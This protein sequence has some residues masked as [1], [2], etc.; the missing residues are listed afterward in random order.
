MNIIP[1]LEKEIVAEGYI[2][3]PPDA[4][5]VKDN[6]E[7]YVLEIFWK[8]MNMKNAHGPEMFFISKDSSL[9]E[10]EYKISILSDKIKIFAST[11]KG[12]IHAFTT[13]YLIKDGDRRFPICE[14]CDRPRYSHRGLHIDCS[15]H[16]FKTNRIKKIIEELS[17]VKINKLHWHL[18]D[19]QGFRV[20]IDKYP[21]LYTQCQG[22]Y[23][24][25]D[26]ICEVVRF[27]KIHGI[28]VIPE[29]D[30]PG[31]TRAMT[32]AYPN[33]SCSEKEVKLATCGGIYP[34]ILCAGKE[35]VYDF[36]RG[37]LEELIPLFE[38]DYFHIGGD[39]APK[40]EWKK[41][42]HCQRTMAMNGLRDEVELQGYFLR[43]IADDISKKYNKKIICWNDSLEFVRY[44]DGTELIQYWTLEHK[45]ALPEFVKKGGHFIYSDMF[46]L[47]YDYVESM[48]P[49]KRSYTC[50][51]VIAG[52]DYSDSGA[53]IGFE[54]CTWT[55]YIENAEMLEKRIFP[56]IYAMAENAWSGGSE[57]G[58][59]DY[60][61]RLK[62]FREKY[63]N[64]I[65]G[66]GDPKGIKKIVEKLQY[67]K[68]MSTGMSPEVREMTVTE[69]S[70]SEEFMQMFKEKMI[71]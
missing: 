13:L 18:S 10:E 38:S 63:S 6:F 40:H 65:W 67:A 49:M 12:V 43:R 17:L 37:I 35:S 56:R 34:V 8:R 19:D 57:V 1:R 11:E 59:K 47:Y 14:I 29:I 27:A 36:I 61:K 70:V 53:C 41:C 55:E 28:E 62:I 71:K 31:H 52:S 24:T 45:E 69:A 44:L 5:V 68:T 25:K 20:Q 3:I 2:T 16:F 22:E 60:K 33:L 39:E 21:K 26:E 32:A 7:D 42:A 51:P 54:A 58:Y 15:R 64:V 4:S 9:E 48:S 50:R 23:Y 46:D 30:M 66:A